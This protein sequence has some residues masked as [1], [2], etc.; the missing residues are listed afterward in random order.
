MNFTK[1]KIN[2]CRLLFGSA[3]MVSVLGS[4][5]SNATQSEVQPNNKDRNALKPSI[6]YKIQENVSQNSLDKNTKKDNI[7][8][9]RS[10]VGEKT[11]HNNLMITQDR[12][13]ARR[14]SKRS[15]GLSKEALRQITELIAQGFAKLFGRAGVIEIEN[16]TKYNL[17]EP[18][19][20]RE[21]GNIQGVPNKIPSQSR[22]NFT[23][24]NN[25]FVIA[26]YGTSGTVSYRLEGTNE[27]IIITWF[28]PVT[29]D[30]GFNVGL[31]DN[32]TP[33][34][35][36]VFYYY[37]NRR[38]KAQ[39]GSLTKSYGNIKLSGIMDTG[40]VA[41]LRVTL[42]DG[43]VNKTPLPRPVN[44][45]VPVVQPQP[46]VKEKDSSSYD[47]DGWDL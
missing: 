29:G 30:N 26:P 13:L 10:G 42:E 4:T 39:R 43:N 3:A 14:S 12:L 24:T 44:R 32:H 33:T 1:T 47:W 40:R 9:T 17:V 16:N 28:V 41:G 31:I 36:G 27:R 7:I 37:H 25:Q 46:P 11:R 34:N 35:K 6:T 15:S 8:A 45:R 20:H 23:V 19:H 5:V 21:D 22:D 2:L 18:L 38:S